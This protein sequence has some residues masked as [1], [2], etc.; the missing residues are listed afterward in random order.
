MLTPEA[1]RKYLSYTMHHGARYLASVI[2]VRPD[3][4]PQKVND[5]HV[6]AMMKVFGKMCNGRSIKDGAPLEVSP[7][8]IERE[9]QR[10][11][12]VKTSSFEYNEECGCNVYDF[13]SISKKYKMIVKVIF[14]SYVDYILY[15]LD[16]CPCNW[17]ADP[18]LLPADRFADTVADFMEFADELGLV[19]IN[20]LEK[21]KKIVLIDTIKKV[22][23]Q[24]RGE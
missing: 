9:F 20:A 10:I 15:S 12:G 18:M 1:K 2:K 3:N 4:S 24:A 21:A 7:W 17:E 8:D 23:K 11:G 14:S 16:G 5:Y 19:A 13:F 6:E 22:T